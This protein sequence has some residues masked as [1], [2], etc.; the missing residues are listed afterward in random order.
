MELFNKLLLERNDYFD[1][2]VKC[3]KCYNESL[4]IKKDM[5]EKQELLSNNVV[6]SKGSVYWKDSIWKSRSVRQKQ[7]KNRYEK[8]LN[9]YRRHIN[10]V[11]VDG[12]FLQ[13]ID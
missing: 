8:F 10:C 6:S 13:R 4:N 12:N 7:D 2:N 11:D 3:K 5:F 9:L 1:I